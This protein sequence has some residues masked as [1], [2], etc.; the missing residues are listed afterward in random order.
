MT[1]NDPSPEETSKSGQKSALF[2]VADVQLA[3]SLL[4]RVP[5]PVADSH[6]EAGRAAWAYPL[7]GL[8]PGA[9]AA[10]VGAL[11][12]TLGLGS[13][14]AAL[15]ALGTSVFVTGALH[16]DGL[17]DCADGFWGGWTSERRLEIMRDSRIGTYGVLALVFSVGLRWAA[18][19][20]LF[21][22]GFGV[23]A[24]LGAAAISR[25]VMPAL[26]TVLPPARPGGLSHHVGAPPAIVSVVSALMA[27]MIAILT[28]GSAAPAALFGAGLAGL[29]IGALAKAKIGG[30]T[31]DVL[32]AS[33][34][35]AE[36]AV[37]LVLVSII[38]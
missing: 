2:R 8:I 36:V 15:L 38:T 26:M 24:L 9:L 12:M 31:G 20:A 30:Q 10:L 3:V 1:K 4:T 32:G 7:A 6:R 35:I 5:F 21:D 28:L 33:Q 19:T 17:A 29:A 27:A 23:L 14:L 37:L 25:A 22:A 16:E 11:A 18:L 13:A 34:Q